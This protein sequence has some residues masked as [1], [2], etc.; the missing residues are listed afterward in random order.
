MTEIFASQT[1]SAASATIIMYE[2]T[3]RGLY[4]AEMLKLRL[5]NIPD[6]I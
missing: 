6:L 2:Q 4:E 1:M 5:K 3:P